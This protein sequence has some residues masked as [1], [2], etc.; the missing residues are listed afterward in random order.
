MEDILSGME[1]AE[2]Q[3]KVHTIL[4]LVDIVQQQKDSI[5]HKDDII[6]S[7]KKTI[8]SQNAM[9]SRHE[10]RIDVLESAL[11]ETDHIRDAQEEKLDQKIEEVEALTKDLRRA[12]LLV[13]QTTQQLAASQEESRDMSNVIRD[14]RTEIAQ[15]N[16][17]PAAQSSPIVGENQRP[18]ATW[19]DERLY[20]F[21]LA[22][23]NL[24]E[25]SNVQA[26]ARRVEEFMTYGRAW[27]Y[28]GTQEDHSITSEDDGKAL[29]DQW[30][31]IFCATKLMIST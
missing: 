25:A 29:K 9:I 4:E 31:F 3:R 30:Y 28:E 16:R 15:V 19:T 5:S 7:Q 11:K 18:D 10:A 13:E 20:R 24:E 17:T 12:T 27:M 2:R 22:I 8:K 21:L 6:A 1:A 14:L 26:S 23:G